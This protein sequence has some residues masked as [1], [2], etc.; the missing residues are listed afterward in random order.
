MSSD[1]PLIDTPSIEI[2]SQCAVHFGGNLSVMLD[3]Y[4]K[5]GKGC[6]PDYSLEQIAALMEQVK[7]FEGP[8]FD[9]LLPED[10]KEAIKKHQKLY[11][12]LREVYEAKQKHPLA[13]AIA[14]LILTEEDDP[15]EEIQAVCSLGYPALEPLHDLLNSATFYDALAPGYGVAPALA[16]RCLGEIKNETSLPILL[17][18]VGHQSFSTDEAIIDAIRS[19][20]DKARKF[21][22]QS[23]TRVPYNNLNLSAAMILS[24]LA[25]DQET[26]AIALAL[27]ENV[28]L[29][30]HETFLSYLVLTLEGLE[31]E[32]LRKKALSLSP[33]LPKSVQEEL[34]LIAKYWSS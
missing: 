27:L 24:S 6:F 22:H 25:P 20:G 23:A 7:E 33:Q 21:L 19:F 28:D 16:A 9:E 30:S 34:S 4:A 15:Q 14:D 17:A 2:L 32:G 31:D 5:E 12:D 29:R 1:F 3:Y 11:Q 8:Q 26:G 13:R 18:A 10:A